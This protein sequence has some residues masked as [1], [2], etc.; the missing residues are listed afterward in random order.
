[1]Q[2]EERDPIGP[3]VPSIDPGAERQLGEKALR[4][5][6]ARLGGGPQQLEGGPSFLGAPVAAEA[7]C[8]EPFPHRA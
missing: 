6:S 1:M 4:V 2:G 3:R 5:V 8:G 7:D